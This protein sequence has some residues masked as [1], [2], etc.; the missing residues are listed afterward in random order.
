[1]RH[2]ALT[3]RAIV[4][5]ASSA[6]APNPISDSVRNHW[7]GGKR[8]LQGSAEQT[9]EENSKSKPTPEVRTFGE[10]LARVATA[11]YVFCAAAKGEKP[12]FDEEHFEKTATTRAAI[13]K[14]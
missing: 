14:A 9:R 7:N 12:P 8:N 1:M 11:S 4:L 6:P 13:V 2:F 3:V 10:S 5:G